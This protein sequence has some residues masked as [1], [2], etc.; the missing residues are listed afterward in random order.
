MRYAGDKI[1]NIHFYENDQN[2]YKYQIILRQCNQKWYQIMQK[3]DRAEGDLRQIHEKLLLFLCWY[4]IYFLFNGFRFGGVEIGMNSPLE[5]FPSVAVEW[6]ERRAGGAQGLSIGIIR[7]TEVE[8]WAFQ[9]N[10]R[11]LSS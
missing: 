7:G 6:E 4:W 10:S 3:E 1:N 2:K 11:C 9:V 8:N 5:G